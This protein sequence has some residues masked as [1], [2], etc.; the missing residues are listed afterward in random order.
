MRGVTKKVAIFQRGAKV[1]GV[2][3]GPASLQNASEKWGPDAL[4]MMAGG[5]S[6]R[7]R[8][9]LASGRQAG[10]LLAVPSEG[11]H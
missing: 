5:V 3:A 1:A 6:K 7:Q 11:G 8:L 2:T 10:L 9:M 4:M